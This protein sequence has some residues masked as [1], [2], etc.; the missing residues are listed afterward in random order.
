M[1]LHALF[2]CGQVASLHAG[3]FDGETRQDNVD[4]VS[5][6]LAEGLRANFEKLRAGIPS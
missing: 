1:A 2:G 4:R 5:P 3:R 6:E